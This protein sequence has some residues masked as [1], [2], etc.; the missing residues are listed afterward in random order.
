VRVRADRPGKLIRVIITVTLNFAL[1]VTYTV[2]EVHVG[3]T[4]RVREVRRRAGGKGVNTARVLHTL[5]EDVAVCGFVGGV[6]G[7]LARA[8]LGRAG[9]R[10]ELVEI[11]GE[12]RQTIVVVDAAGQATGFSEA[13]PHPSG[14]EW[15]ALRARLDGLLGQASALVIAGSVPPGVPG[16][17]CAQ[18]VTAARAAG[19]P[20]LVD[21]AGAWLA[22]G[23]SAGPAIVKINRA[24]L[25]GVVGAGSDVLAGARTLRGAGPELVAVTCGAEGL[26][27][28]G[29]SGAWRAAP[30][31]AMH[32]NPTGAGDA[33]SAALARWLAAGGERTGAALPDALADAVALSAAAVA[34]PL[35]GSFDAAV[36][37]ELRGA[38]VLERV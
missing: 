23:L 4:V 38:V 17:G 3:E 12:S 5:G 2:A 6:H 20:A 9:L 1:D 24:E 25:R 7:E 27:A 13:G 35:A 22:A 10:D 11:A 26:V 21:T 28:V 16:D 15:A 29:D 37:R 33:A 18:L 32:G 34:A 14:A 8:E 19:V 30:P 36:Y 31:R